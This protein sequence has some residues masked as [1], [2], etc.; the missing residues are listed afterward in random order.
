MSFDLFDMR[1]LLLGKWTAKSCSKTRMVEWFDQFRNWIFVNMWICSKLFQGVVFSNCLGSVVKMRWIVCIL[2]LNSYMN[3]IF[4]FVIIFSNEFYCKIPPS[5]HQGP[6]CILSGTF[7]IYVENGK[8]FRFI[9]MT[10]LFLPEKQEKTNRRTTTKKRSPMLTYVD[11]SEIIM[12]SRVEWS[13]SFI[14]K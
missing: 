13:T 7:Q 9:L 1:F 8:S 5:T 4:V 3:K 10:P 12:K 14:W 6:H 2:H 11:R